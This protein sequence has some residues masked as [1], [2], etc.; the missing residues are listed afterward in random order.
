M[1]D[2]A[3]EMAVIERQC[4]EAVTRRLR[5]RQMGEAWN[6][7]EGYTHA[8]EANQQQAEAEQRAVQQ[9]VAE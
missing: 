6:G 3:Y 1:F 8:Q 4:Y 2:I 5:A 7:L 9:V